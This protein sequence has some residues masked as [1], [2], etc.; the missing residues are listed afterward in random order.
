MSYLPAW[1][2]ASILYID[3]F[4]PLFSDQLALEIGPGISALPI[5]IF[6]GFVVIALLFSFRRQRLRQLVGPDEL[7]LASWLPPG[8]FSL[9]GLVF[10]AA[11]L[12]RVALWVELLVRGQIPLFAGIERFDYTRLL[13]ARCIAAC[14][15]GDPC[16]RSKSAYLCN[17]LAAQRAVGPALRRPVRVLASAG[18]R[19]RPVQLILGNLTARQ[20]TADTV[21]VSA[22]SQRPASPRRHSR[23]SQ[24]GDEEQR[25]TPGPLEADIKERLAASDT[26]IASLVQTVDS[27]LALA[28]E[29]LKGVSGDPAFAALLRVWLSDLVSRNE[30][31]LAA[32]KAEQRALSATLG[33]WRTYPT[34]FSTN[35]THRRDLRWPDL[36]R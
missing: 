30:E 15:N 21:A 3:V 1:R 9:S 2:L 19:N 23:R 4:G 11:A 32:A 6:Q 31:R 28:R 27:L 13:G 14:W 26:T 29:D 24:S 7:G 10:L 34:T 35:P 36:L 18:D 20:E 12:F 5:A 33:A 25:R 22:R 16:W 8:R 17:S